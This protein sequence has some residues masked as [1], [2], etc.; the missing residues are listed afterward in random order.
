MI[1]IILAVTF[2]A[3]VGLVAVLGLAIRTA[4]NLADPKPVVLARAGA[5]D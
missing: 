3:A 2:L 5:S 4:R 1:T